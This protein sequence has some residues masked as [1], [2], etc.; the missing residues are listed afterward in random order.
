MFF[1][2]LI[3]SDQEMMNEEV[4]DKKQRSTKLVQKKKK[5]KYGP[6]KKKIKVKRKQPKMLCI[7]PK[8]GP[9]SEPDA[10][11]TNI[12]SNH[13]PTASVVDASFETTIDLAIESAIRSAIESVQEPID[14]T[15]D[16]TILQSA[17]IVEPETAS[18]TRTKP[19]S[20]RKYPVRKS[21]R[22]QNKKNEKGHRQ[23]D[24]VVNNDNKDN[25]DRFTFRSQR[26]R[27]RDYIASFA[28]LRKTID[29]EGLYRLTKVGILDSSDYIVKSSELSEFKIPNTYDLI[30]FSNYK[31]RPRTNRKID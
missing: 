10:R 19:K 30:D 9:S 31:R 14:K 5:R 24:D 16:E 29:P 12:E 8:P 13:E 25:K 6:S 3:F 4:G 11:A 22:I 20:T 27:R 28:N 26:E 2:S 15:I 17:F 23:P 7:L 18:Q 21:K 1:F